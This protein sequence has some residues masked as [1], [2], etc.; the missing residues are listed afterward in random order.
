[1][2]KI[3]IKPN[4]NN[5]IGKKVRLGY[6]GKNHFFEILFVGKE[7]MLG[8]DEEERETSWFINHNWELYKCPFGDTHENTNKTK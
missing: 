7:K 6:W 8:K 5:Q 3:Q 4:D 2:S 1:M